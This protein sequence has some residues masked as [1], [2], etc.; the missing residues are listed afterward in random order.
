MSDPVL[1]MAQGRIAGELPAAEATQD[2]VKARGRPH[3]H[4][5]P[6]PKDWHGTGRAPVATETLKSDTGA[7]GTSGNAASCSTTARS[8]P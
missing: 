4:D 3:T 5:H 8:A 1:V 2:A 6:A 7:G